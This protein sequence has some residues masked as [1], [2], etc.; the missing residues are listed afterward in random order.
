MRTTPGI[1]VKLTVINFA[2]GHATNNCFGTSSNPM[3]NRDEFL[4]KIFESVVSNRN[5]PIKI[6]LTECYGY[7]YYQSK[8]DFIK[9][10][11]R[12]KSIHSLTNND[13]PNSLLL[14]GKDKIN[15]CNINVLFYKANEDLQL[16]KI[17]LDLYNLFQFCTHN[18][19]LTDK[20]NNIVCHLIT[21]PSTPTS[22]TPTPTITN[23][24]TSNNKIT[25]TTHPNNYNTSSTISTSTSSSTNTSEPN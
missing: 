3:M 22:T 21:D 24:H 2:H 6:I 15:Y 1:F 10:D 19:A 7:K 20:C 18:M 23:T 4:D 9:I 16:F 13:N 12:G 8:K 5:F 17:L 14:I 11:L 25:T